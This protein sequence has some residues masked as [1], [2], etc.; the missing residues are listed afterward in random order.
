[1]GGMS[2]MAAHK[3]G[4]TWRRHATILARMQSREIQAMALRCPQEYQGIFCFKLRVSLETFS[5]DVANSG[6]AQE[7]L[8]EDSRGMQI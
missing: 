4:T 8:S 5:A 7:K 2:T 3:V 6:E 1:M